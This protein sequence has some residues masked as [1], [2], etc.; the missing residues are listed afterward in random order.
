MKP[1]RKRAA[2]ALI[3]IMIE[4]CLGGC[5][6]RDQARELD[7]LLIVQTL[8][9]DSGGPGLVLSL[10]SRGR[11]DSPPER[12]TASGASVTEALERVR[13]GT[14]EEELFCAHLGHLLIGEPAAGQGIAPCLDYVCRSGDLRLNVPVYVLRGAEAREAVL[15]AGDESFGASDALDAV[16]ADLRD[17]GD[18]R[19]TTAA[20]LLRDLSRRGSALVCAVALRDS[21]EADQSAEAGERPRTLVPD[22]Y[23]VLRDGRLCGYLDREQ[24][25]G[26][27]LLSGQAGLAELVVT[28]QAGLPVT[29]SITGGSSELEPRFDEGGGLCALSVSVKAEAVLAESAAGDTELSYLQTMAERAISDRVRQTLQLS[30]LWQADFL[31]LEGMLERR[32]PERMRAQEPAFAARWPSLPLTVSVSVRLTGTGDVE[33]AP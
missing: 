17:R 2:I 23:A 15:G 8:G 12:L 28:D 21:A 4:L 16:D 1:Y 30:K 27:G 22:G 31:G 32:A 26:V 6:L 9:F 18:G 20:E 33:D 10:S 24:A 7:Q 14:N 19:I 11:E 5:G 29:L 25:L 13:S 3:I